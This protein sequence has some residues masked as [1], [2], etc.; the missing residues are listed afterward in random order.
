MLDRKVCLF[1]TELGPLLP[2]HGDLT[3]ARWLRLAGSFSSEARVVSGMG[4]PS[5]DR[6]A[7]P[8][9]SIFRSVSTLAQVTMCLQVTEAAREVELLALVLLW[10]VRSKIK[11]FSF[12]ISGSGIVFP[13]TGRQICFLFHL[14]PHHDPS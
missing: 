7:S 4:Q 13:V 2:V 3:M 14:R 11:D 9:G 8:A 12:S 6:L 10:R 5:S 1:I